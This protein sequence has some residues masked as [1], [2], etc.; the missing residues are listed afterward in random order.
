MFQLQSCL[1]SS[2]DVVAPDTKNATPCEVNAHFRV[3]CPW[4]RRFHGSVNADVLVR[5]GPFDQVED[6]KGAESSDSIW[7]ACRK[8]KMP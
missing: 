1:T 3:V 6:C 8:L 5:S 7:L 2:K 4:S